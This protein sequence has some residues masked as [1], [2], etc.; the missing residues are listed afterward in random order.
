MEEVERGHFA[1]DWPSSHTSTRVP[2]SEGVLT[3]AGESRQGSLSQV[4]AVL[5]RE[6]SS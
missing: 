1:S 4:G 6:A 2:A 5:P 3:G